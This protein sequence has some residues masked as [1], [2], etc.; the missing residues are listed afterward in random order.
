MMYTAME[1]SELK[2]V[3]SAQSK[4]TVD[5]FKPHRATLGSIHSDSDRNSKWK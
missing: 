5:R 1:I 3:R 2:G 4:R